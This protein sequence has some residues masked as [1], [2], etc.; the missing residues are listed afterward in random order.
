MDKSIH[1]YEQSLV[2][3]KRQQEQLELVMQKMGEEWNESGPGINW[4]KTLQ[5]PPLQTDE[6]TTKTSTI[7]DDTDLVCLASPST[8][9]DNMTNTEEN[10]RL[11]HIFQQP[12]PSPEYLQSLLH[13]NETLLA[14][15]LAST[16]MNDHTLETSNETSTYST[17]QF[18][19]I[20]TSTVANL[21]T[22][23]MTPSDEES[24]NPSIFA[25]ITSPGSTT[26]TN[27]IS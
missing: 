19:P 10:D 7:R 20:L 12:Q 6:L 3:L 27:D 5:S 11:F 17:C 15:S 2:D 8:P 23:P 16:A 24:G 22:P 1:D 4:L 13:V 26:T 9:D 25:A 21:N 18:T 14:Q